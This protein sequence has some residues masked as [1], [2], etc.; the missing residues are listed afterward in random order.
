MNQF[1]KVTVMVRVDMD[2][3]IWHRVIV[4]TQLTGATGSRYARYQTLV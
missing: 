2:L 4:V 3:G 1:Y